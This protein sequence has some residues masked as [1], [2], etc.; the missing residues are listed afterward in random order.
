[1]TDD[2]TG[3]DAGTTDAPTPE[4]LDHL[5]MDVREHARPVLERDCPEAD[6][7]ATEH[8]LTDQ[9]P[10]T[11]PSGAW[12]KYLDPVYRCQ[13]CGTAHT[14]LVYETDQDADRPEWGP[15]PPEEDG[16][17]LEG[18]RADAPPFESWLRAASD[19]EGVLVGSEDAR[20]DDYLVSVERVP[21]GEQDA[22]ADVTDD[23]GIW[24]GEQ[25]TVN[26]ADLLL[27]LEDSNPRLAR[28]IVAAVRAVNQGDVEAAVDWLETATERLE[29]TDD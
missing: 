10:A 6:C 19:V 13:G 2:D 29:E 14:L 28:E 5:R 17:D 26:A 25:E 15:Y 7:E 23:L 22:D 20:D 12:G 1:M 24:N 21:R 27:R 8:H 16:D 9:Y 3:T 18:L 4:D 11:V